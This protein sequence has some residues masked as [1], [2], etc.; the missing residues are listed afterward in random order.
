MGIAPS[1]SP[2]ASA[3]PV[4]SQCVPVGW[5]A[6]CPFPASDHG[7]PPAAPPTG[8]PTARS[9]TENKRL[10]KYKYS[11]LAQFLETVPFLLMYSSGSFLYTGSNF[12]NTQIRYHFIH[13]YY[14]VLT[15][16][17]GSISFTSTTLYYCLVPAPFH[18]PV[19]HY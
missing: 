2:R 18:S 13:Q 14:F 6:R 7:S 10:H 4:W 19:L 3:D 1:N 5:N 11:D 17:Y 16:E 15:L 9:H 8:P 12:I